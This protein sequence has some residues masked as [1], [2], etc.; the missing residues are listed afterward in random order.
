M[1]AYLKKVINVTSKTAYHTYKFAWNKLSFE[2]YMDGKL[3]TFIGA[4][5][6][7]TSLRK[8]CSLI[9]S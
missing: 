7:C 2:F 8:G 6:P 9:P 3:I 5:F 4:L 1:D